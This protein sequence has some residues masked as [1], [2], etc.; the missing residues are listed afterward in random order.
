MAD[1]NFTKSNVATPQKPSLRG[2]DVGL[3]SDWTRRHFDVEDRGQRVMMGIPEALARLNEFTAAERERILFMC[4]VQNKRHGLCPE[5]WRLP[6]RL[7][8]YKIHR[9]W[10]HKTREQEIARDKAD[11]ASG[12]MR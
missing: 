10:I 4:W 1:Y 12:E 6:Y 7:E 8:I 9:D 3:G 2:W 5:V 11:A